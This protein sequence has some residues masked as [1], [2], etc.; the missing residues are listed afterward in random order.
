MIRKMMMM[1]VA[2][3]WTAVAFAQ[4]LVPLDDSSSVT[5]VIKNLG[6]NVKG[7][8]TGLGGTIRFDPAQPEN[9]V[10]DVF[11]DAATVNTGNRKRDEHLQQADFFDVK[12]F[13]HIKFVSTKVSPGKKA[14][15]FF[16][17]G[18][19]TIKSISLP[20]SFPFSVEP[21]AGGY[22]MEGGFGTRRKP[23]GVGRTSTI[24]NKLSVSLQVLALK[25]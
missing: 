5:F 13:P 18:T 15:T 11:V 10:F 16:M 6:I 20:I 14:G 3:T 7:S 24:A 8:F 19:L 9:S 12:N 17:E 2:I 1:W 4:N 25:A 21:V 23:Y 22:R